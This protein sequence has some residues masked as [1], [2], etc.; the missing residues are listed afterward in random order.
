[1]EVESIAED[2]EEVAVTDCCVRSALSALTLK[3]S[4]A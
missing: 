3:R 2:A 1:M 4:L